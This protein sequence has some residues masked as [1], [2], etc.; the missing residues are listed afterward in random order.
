MKLLTI[1]ALGISTILIYASYHI[2]SSSYEDDLATLEKEITELTYN[3]T[4]YKKTLGL[5]GIDVNNLDSEKVLEMI[6]KQPELIELEKKTTIY[7]K[8]SLD[9]YFKMCEDVNILKGKGILR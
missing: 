7:T 5:Y 3:N 9:E 2:T 1:T 8:K 6:S 4:N